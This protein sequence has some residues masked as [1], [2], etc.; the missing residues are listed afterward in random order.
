MDDPFSMNAPFPNRSA[1]GRLLAEKLCAHAAVPGVLVLA[2]P[3]G[4]VPVAAEVA[5]A[6]HVPLDVF[7]VRKLGLPAQPELAMGA[8]AAGGV[9][10]LNPGVV[11]AGRLPR[12]VVEAVAAHEQLELERRERAY[13]EGLPPLD[14]RGKLVL[15][16]DDGIATGSTMLAAAMAL[17]RMGAG[18]VVLVAPVVARDTL[19]AMLAA[20]REVVCLLSPVDFLSV[21]QWYEDFDQTTDEEVREILARFRGRGAASAW[22]DVSCLGKFQPMR[23]EG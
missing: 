15:L 6:L 7:V 18:R 1:A 20:D 2:L 16:V 8:I 3:R 21:G 4:G 19:E 5:E 17:D 23:G 10:V 12:E 9:L 11:E 22:Q 13:R 14:V